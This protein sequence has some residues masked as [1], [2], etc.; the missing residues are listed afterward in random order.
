MEILYRSFSS[1][2]GVLLQAVYPIGD[3]VAWHG[4]WIRLFFCLRVAGIFFSPSFFLGLCI[5]FRAL[6][7][8]G[9][10]ARGSFSPS[11]ADA[12]FSSLA[13][14][15][16]RKSFSSLLVSRPSRFRRRV[17]FNDSVF[18]LVT[19]YFLD[20]RN[21]SRRFS[22]ARPSSRVGESRVPPPVFL[23]SWE[24][25]FSLSLGGRAFLRSPNRAF[26]PNF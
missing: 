24:L 12:G 11:S 1:Y 4:L 13:V 17:S 15:L 25:V 7:I 5:F 2:P 6:P 19:F 20:A 16:Y 9:I 8:R 23:Q 21:V 18:S 14:P 10:G 26:R 3:R 22:A